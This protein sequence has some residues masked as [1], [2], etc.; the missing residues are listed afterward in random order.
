LGHTE[1][2]VSVV[3]FGGKEL[4]NVEQAN[5]DAALNKALELGINYIDTA[6]DYLDSERKIGRAIGNRRREFYLATRTS[7]RDA[8]GAQ[9]DLDT[10]LNELQMDSVDVYQLHNVSTSE[11]YRQVMATGGAF[12]ALLEAKDQGLVSHVGITIH[13]ALPLMRHAIESGAFETI[14]LSYSLIDQEN[15]EAEI[16][17]M[18][19][20]HGLGVV[21]EKPLSGGLLVTPR[22][23]GEEP[24]E[25][26]PI[27]Q[28]SL[29][30]VTSND[31]V[32][33]TIPSMTG[34][35][36]VEENAEVGSIESKMSRRQL[37]QLRQ[38]IGDLGQEFKYGQVCLRCGH[39]QPC[40][41]EV[42]ITDIFRAVDMYRSYPKEL[43]DLGLRLYQSQNVKAEECMECGECVANCPANLEIPDLL[44]EAAELFADVD[45]SQV[46]D[47]DK[48]V[49]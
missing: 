27:V 49:T 12:E 23:S 11:A 25:P 26:D 45:V 37:Y 1:L 33:L 31:A 16:L 40:P 47:V 19:R 13:R 39:C 30:Y 9:R 28:G 38:Q 36:E 7:A 48:A 5:A 15:V 46:L 17:P 3:G 22:T 29:W 6:R 24:S 20:E 21:I 4:P 8:E 32:S 35:G 42:P 18:A 43:R 2:Q 44:E 10:S 14:M 34:V 41:N